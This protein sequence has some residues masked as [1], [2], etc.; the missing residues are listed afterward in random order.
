MVVKSI[1]LGGDFLI[2]ESSPRLFSGFLSLKKLPIHSKVSVWSTKLALELYLIPAGVRKLELSGNGK[3]LSI[4]CLV[5]T[6]QL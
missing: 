5:K 6:E 1:T 4:C 2:F 3:N